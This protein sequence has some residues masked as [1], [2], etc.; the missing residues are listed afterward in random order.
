MR[1]LADYFLW[2]STP[3]LRFFKD[4][5]KGDNRACK[6]TGFPAIEGWDPVTGMGY[7]FHLFTRSTKKMMY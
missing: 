3:T 5:V 6:T 1:T 2:H 7:V 4:I